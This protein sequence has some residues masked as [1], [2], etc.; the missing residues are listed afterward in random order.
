ML[1][2]ILFSIL[3]LTLVI[4]FTGCKK[5][6]IEIVPVISITRGS[7]PTGRTIDHLSFVSQNVGYAASSLSDTIFRTMNGGAD[8]EPIKVNTGNAGCNGLCFLDPDTGLVVMGQTLYITRNAGLSWNYVSE[9]SF[10]GCTNSG[11]VVYGRWEPFNQR[12]YLYKSSNKGG[13]FQ[14]LNGSFPA[15]DG[16]VKGDLVLLKYN[17]FNPQSNTVDPITG[18]TSFAYYGEKLRDGYFEG[19]CGTLVGDNGLL[20]NRCIGGSGQSLDFVDKNQ[21][22]AVDGAPGQYRFA[23]G[24]YAMMTNMVVE[25]NGGWSPVMDTDGNGISGLFYSIDMLPDGTFF[26]GGVSGSFMKCRPY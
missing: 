23:V 2:R 4:T 7:I 14:G 16:S 24:E 25:E 3:A 13:S 1:I 18:N 15:G 22:K 21:F 26:V 12:N 11:L 6:Y 9:A 17:S 10:V 8:W 20:E 5:E 19:S